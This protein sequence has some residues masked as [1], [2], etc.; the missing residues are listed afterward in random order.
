M[1][2]PCKPHNL[3][4]DDDAYAP[5]KLNKGKQKAE[6]PLDEEVVSPHV[7]G[8]RLSS[9]DSDRCFAF[10][11]ASESSP[12]L[13]SIDTHPPTNVA[14]SDSGDES[15]YQSVDEENSSDNQK[16]DI[17]APPQAHQ[18][19]ELDLGHSIKGM[20]RILDLIS[21]QSSGGLVDKI[22]I[23]QN[24][25]EAFI[26]NVCPGAYV[27]MTRV[28]FRVLD[29]FAIKPVGVYGSKVE[30]VRFL[31]QLGAIPEIIATQLLIDSD[32]HERTRPA[33][34]SGLYIITTPE[35]TVGSHQIFVL[36]WPEQTTWDDSAVSSVRRNRITFMR[37]LTKMCDQV[38]SLISPEH[39]QTILW[40]EEDSSG[41]GGDNINQEESDRA[42]TFV[43][44]QTSEQEESVVVREGF[45]AISP[46]IVLPKAPA[47]DPD[48]AKP[49]PITPFLLSGETTQGF[50]TV[51]HREAEVT[52]EIFRGDLISAM[53]LETFLKSDR[54]CLDQRLDDK[55]IQILVRCGLEKRFQAPCRK[56]KS[57]SDAIRNTSDSNTKRERENMSTKLQT[58]LPALRRSLFEA[59]LDEVLQLYPCFNR[60]AFAY[61]GDQ[62]E[63]S[64]NNPV[65][66]FE[67]LRSYPKTNQTATQALRNDFQNISNQDFQ[68][69]KNHISVFKEL[70]LLLATRH[71]ELDERTH[72]Q[73]L[74]A[75]LM[76]NME[77]VKVNAKG[78]N[79][80]GGGVRKQNNMRSILN[81]LSWVPTLLSLSRT[82][83]GREL[84]GE[85]DVLVHTATEAATHVSDSQF[86]SQLGQDEELYAQHFPQFKVLADR[87]RNKAFEY[88]NVTLTRT[89]KKLMPQVE[90]TQAEECAEGIKRK[91][92]KGAEEMQVKLRKNLIKDLNDLSLQ[93]PHSHT[94]SID[95][96][97]QSYA[98][99]LSPK[100]FQI[101]C[102][103]STQRDQTALLY[104][105]HLM[106]LTA[107][108]RHELQLNP[109]AIPSPQFRF[110]HKFSLP[111]GHSVVRAQL[112]E[113]EK[114]LLVVADRAGNLIV[115]LDRLASMDGAIPIRGKSLNR[116]KIGQ[117]FL[118]AYDES[119]S[120]LAVVSSDKLL[121]NIFVFDDA[122]GFQA[123]GSVIDLRQWYSEV[124]SIRLACFVSGSEELVLVDSHLQAR[125]FSLVTLQFRPATLR[126]DQVPCS[127][128]STPDGACLLVA[129]TRGSDVLVTAYHW[130]T[131]GSTE[132]TPLDLAPLT[133]KNGLVVT[134]LISRTAVHIVVLD[135][136]TH[137]CRSQALDITRKVTEYAF[138]EK[139]VRGSSA[140]HVAG[141]EGR[142]TT[143]HNCLIDCHADVWTRFPVLPAVQRETISPLSL[144]SARTLVFVTDRDY[145][146]Y[147]PRFA[148]MILKFERATKK[149]TGD[150]LKS[151]QVSAARFVVFAAELCGGGKHPKSTR[152]RAW[153]V[154]DYRAGEWLVEFL[155][156]IP[157]HL[158][159]A[160]ENRFMPL[161]DGV[162]SPELE[163]S[164]LGADVNC[165]VDSLSFGWYESL[166][167]SYMASK[168][169]KV[170]SSMGEQSVGK[171]FALNHLVDTSFAGSAMRT[172][173]GVWMSVT[174]TKDAL[175][176]ALDFEGVHSIERSAQE[177]T[178]LVLFNTAISNLVL[179]RNNFALSR[180]ITGLFQSFQSSST[181]LDPKANPSLFQ[182]TLVIIIKDVVDS[183]KVEI[184]KEFSLKFQRIVQDE[185]EANFISRLHAGK[186]NIIPWP[187]IESKEFYKLFPTLTRWLDQQVVTHRSAGE[188]LHLMKTLMAK[189]KANDWG[190]MSQ[191]MASHRAGLISTLL[192]DALAFG[193]INPDREPLKNLD[194]D[195]LI[196]LPDAPYQLSIGD[197]GDQSA[198]RDRFLMALRTAWEGYASR[199]Y[200]PEDEWIASLTQHLET[201]VNLRIAH[202]REW[203]N[204]NLSRFQPVG[205]GGSHERIDELKR[206][207][208]SSIVD[209][210]GNVQ[211][212]G[213]PCA[214]CQLRCIQSRAH[215]GAHDCQSGHLCV[216]ECDFCLAIEPGEHRPCTMSAGHAGKHICIVNK[217]LCGKPC[218]FSGRQGCLDMCAK[219]IDHPDEEHICAAPVHACGKPCDLS[220]IRLV[221][222]SLYS[223]PGTC[224]IPS[225]I[226]HSIHQ[227]DARLCSI[228]C[229]LC[230]RLCADRDHMHGLD[231]SAIHLC[232]QEHLCTVLCAA[233]GICEID[234]APHSIEA[235]FTGR[236]ETFQYT[237]VCFAKRLRCIKLIPPGAR[238]HGGP[239]NH[240]LDMKIVHFCEARCANC[241]YFCTL[242][243]GHPQ[244]QHETRHGSMS[245]TRWTVDG[246]DD[247]PL[248]IE[249]RKF[250]TNDEGAPM[251]CNLVC[252]AMG[253]HVHIDYCRADDKGAC[254]GNNELQH[255][256]R[257]IQPDPDRAKDVLTHGLIWKRSGFKD[258]YSREEQT[259][260]GKC[261]AMCGGPEHTAASGGAAIPSY[262]V[263][264][265]FHAPLNPNVAPAMGYISQDGHQFACRNPVVMQQA[266]HVIFVADH[267]GSMGSRDLQPL[268]NTPATAR[269]KSYANNRYGAVLSSLYSYWTARAAAITGSNT[270]R[271]DAYSVVLFDHGFATP[272]VDDFASTP[273]QLLGALLG[274][275]TNG[276]TNFTLAIQQAQAIMQENWSTERSPVIIFLSDG[277]CEIGDNIMQDLCRTAIRLGKAVSFHAVSFGPEVS[278]THLRRMA[279]IARDV[280]NNAPRDPLVPAAATVLSSY[281]RA[282]DTV[283]YARRIVVPVGG[284]A[285]NDLSGGQK[286]PAIIIH[287]TE[288]PRDRG[289][290]GSE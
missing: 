235:T 107:Q 105:V 200:T 197:D 85:L 34:R 206:H 139:G 250:S 277:D 11:P 152:N 289:F 153:N 31:L 9:F 44:A 281:T 181:V 284:R 264:P 77:Q 230:K 282:L 120:M 22:I 269:I 234:T 212:C 88:L 204:Q 57:D 10:E 286:A 60:G 83:S 233:P 222:E 278:S 142:S 84:N 56:W 246:P 224:R 245:R 196:D 285:L 236:N 48:P 100:S 190:A 70:P 80:A 18:R 17:D 272:V 173:E 41:D 5:S 76:G 198:S 30:L 253:R 40:S 193:Y 122:R 187:V 280:Q 66:L 63:K 124:L 98:S 171:S 75:V 188:F 242:P 274:F 47:E 145:Q 271:R 119:K 6:D 23:S 169:V 175:I 43:V 95:D 231:S 151:I 133:V 183:D 101:Y 194:T 45:K 168:P 205:G 132:G 279:E 141:G 65:P 78:N 97:T 243:L 258:P 35:Q 21:E 260:F 195:S 225:D 86:L 14:G 164:L 55:A 52:Q 223:C 103:R 219:V 149:P 19:D 276:G 162:Y 163:R 3:F 108:D 254:T 96:V 140:R 64:I 37:Y 268:A 104:T 26:N 177:D 148:E 33:L 81:P 117:D 203:L 166:F 158:A 69:A 138:K 218:R 207:F 232:G 275:S 257:K 252:S 130:S 270:T 176:V 213:L 51:E 39:A 1:D 157:I 154:S 265:L 267:S 147:A 115:Y 131:F 167:Q 217:H 146:N 16:M 36:Y 2:P 266:F 263:L 91:H 160:K 239:H 240:S 50:M 116:E 238:G 24:S 87:A 99:S 211:L 144:R 228:Q 8:V 247:V 126:L 93:T 172:T 27:S 112:L 143:A 180:D 53:Q 165:I 189:L 90:K 46:A 123:L 262:C 256:T 192:T 68:T 255:L 20:Y 15:L 237:K 226:D 248:E 178:L 161:K 72:M 134:S 220:S 58:K 202:V 4:G 170:V 92:A 208:E 73:I 111:L 114:L 61:H 89:L 287:P 129:Q 106:N 227:C 32:T 127:V 259:N 38:V 113:G 25:L 214:A 82:T 54:L 12:P 128:S 221:D 283:P 229:Q 261:D 156:L 42:F 29:N 182:S 49:A 273:D 13:I 125:V 7:Q 288:L 102:S 186:L 179:F 174:P 199:Q 216:H 251:M 94:L 209:L 137:A 121:L 155:C 110:S 135:F 109:S 62:G 118:L 185:Q 290:C 71:L 159:L 184:T 249:G 201:I 215:E 67:I 241:N 136:E 59:I 191:T 28:N 74:E 150:I 210:R 244:Q 79:G